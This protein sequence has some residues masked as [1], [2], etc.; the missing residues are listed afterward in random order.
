[1]DRKNAW[2]RLNS[3]SSMHAA[4]GALLDMPPM[5][6]ADFAYLNNKLVRKWK[7]VNERKIRGGQLKS[8]GD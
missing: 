5:S 4:M 2:K 7:K 8:R 3:F 1:M 6:Q